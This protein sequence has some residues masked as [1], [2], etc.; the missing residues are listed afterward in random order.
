MLDSRVSSPP[1]TLPPPFDAHFAGLEEQRYTARS[2]DAFHH[3]FGC[4]P[5]HPRGLRVRCFRTPDGVASP[6]VIPATYAGPPGAAHGGIVAAYLD[7]ILA[8]AIV[9]AT[10][11][12]CVTGELTVRYVA[13]AP[14]E[15]PIVG[16][17][18]L[19]A[20]HGRYVDAEG[21]LEELQTGRLLARARGRFFRWAGEG[22]GAGPLPGT[23]RRG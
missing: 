8:A 14:V 15:T 7:E 11:Q 3:C 22:E 1:D 2:D 4:G 17:G 12:I 18:R 19:V 9:R 23:I 20:D 16:R 21:E 5:A 13:P 6:I 10:G